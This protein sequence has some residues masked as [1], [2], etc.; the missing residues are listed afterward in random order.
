M[1]EGGG[2]C[3]VRDLSLSAVVHAVI[4]SSFAGRRAA[5]MES[6]L[7]SYVDDLYAFSEDY[8]VEGTPP[9]DNLPLRDTDELHSTQVDAA[10]S[11]TQRST[12]GSYVAY[13]YTF[14]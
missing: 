9:A 7:R 12:E 5:E 11:E 6:E 3:C 13:A 4:E 2:A 10:D 14:V 8:G 1:E